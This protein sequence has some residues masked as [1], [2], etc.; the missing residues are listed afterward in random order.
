M[1]TLLKTLP[2]LCILFIL[3]ACTDQLQ[4]ETMEDT[5]ETFLQAIIDGDTETIEALNRDPEY[6][7]TEVMSKF[8][9]MLSGMNLEDLEMEFDKE[10]NE[11]QF[12]IDSSEGGFYWLNIEL[13]GERYFVTNVS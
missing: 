5:A 2:L 8:G 11:L 9:P 7:S 13:I 3:S 12:H 1:R 6:P 4:N 10:K